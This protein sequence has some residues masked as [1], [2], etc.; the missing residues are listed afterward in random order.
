[1]LVPMDLPGDSAEK[2]NNK[3]GLR[4]MQNADLRFD[5]GATSDAHAL[6]GSATVEA[7]NELLRNSRMW[8]GWEALG[9]RLHAF[10]AARDYALDRQQFGRPLAKSQLIQQDLAEMISNASACPGLM[11]QIARLQTA[12]S[13]DMVHAAMAKSTGTRLLRDSVA[14]ARNI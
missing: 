12:G 1:F 3:I 7:A 14:R 13:V 9:A 11:Q 8:V 10:D 2:I 4:V 6:A 5:Q